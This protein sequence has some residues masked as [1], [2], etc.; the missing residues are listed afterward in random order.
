MKLKIKNNKSISA[1]IITKDRPKYFLKAIK[2]VL[3]QSNKVNE[4]IVID[5]GKKK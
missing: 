1:I 3:N 4:I 2:S 5:N